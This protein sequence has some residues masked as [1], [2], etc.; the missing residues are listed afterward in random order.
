MATRTTARILVVS[1]RCSRGEA[2]DLT[3]PRLLR[4]LAALGWE[5]AGVSIVPDDRRAIS[6]TLRSWTGG[7]R[8][9]VILTAGG[10]GLGPRDVTP[11]ATRAV[12]RKEADGI[13]QLMRERGVRKTPRAALSRAAAGTRGN[14][15]IVNLPGSPGGAD[16]SL[17]A[18][19]QILPHA[20]EMV[21]GR[22]HPGR[23]AARR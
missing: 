15:V 5:S 11:E 2:P 20:L 10:T 14:C 18:I 3:G 7:R 4:R 13:V 17:V 1:D 21:A 9:L 8:P 12:L 6:R 19:A 16:E 22:G 23:R